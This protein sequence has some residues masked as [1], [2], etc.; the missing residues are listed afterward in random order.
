MALS[1]E[2]RLP[3]EVEPAV[4]GRGVALL[5]PTVAALVLGVNQ[6]AARAA[7]TSALSYDGKLVH[8]KWDLARDADM[9]GAA[10]VIGDSSA[11]FG[12]DTDVLGAELGVPAYNLGTYGRFQATGA[13]WMLDEALRTSSGPPRV[14]IVVLG[15]RS[16]VLES[17][18]DV[19]AQIPA[20]WLGLGSRV[21]GV[22]LGPVMSL[23]F[24][25]A[26][27]LPLLFQHPIYARAIRNWEFE[28]DLSALQIAPGGTGKIPEP[29]PRGVRAFAQRTLDEFEALGRPLV[30]PRERRA[31]EGLV[32][33]AEERGYPLVFVDSPVW[34]ELAREAAQVEA[35]ETLRG[36]IDAACEGAERATRL[37]GGP[38]TFTEQQM[39]NPFHLTVDGARV[40]SERLGRALRPLLG[41]R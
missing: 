40:Y 22:A 7:P 8:T 1:L 16:F 11:C 41:S 29:N 15:T 38:W 19:F 23:E 36:A 28:R 13:G 27:A 10:V 24:L 4:S 34:E 6:L 30:S 17:S 3:G 32:K 9:A 31:F 5:L 21:P 20:G 12:V 18:G 33:D 37:E 35:L 25:G 14:V 26:R 39:E 2:E